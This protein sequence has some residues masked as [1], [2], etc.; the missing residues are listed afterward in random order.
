MGVLS[1]ARSGLRAARLYLG[2]G[3]RSSLRA[4]GLNRLRTGLSLRAAGLCL[5]TACLGTSN[6]S[7]LRTGLS[8][9]AARLNRLRSRSKTEA[10]LRHHAEAETAALSAASGSLLTSALCATSDLLASALCATS[11]LLASALRGSASAKA[12]TACLRSDSKTTPALL[13]APGSLLTAA[14][15]GNTPAKALT[16]CLRSDS[17]SGLRA[18]LGTSAKAE[19]LLSTLG[20][21][22]TTLSALEGSGL[23]SAKGRLC[24][25]DSGRSDSGEKDPGDCES[26]N[27]VH[28]S[29]LIMCCLRFSLLSHRAAVPSL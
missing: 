8:L 18:A 11:D 4:A 2:T 9:R 3:N 6:W 26:K 1:S 7:G 10:S 5:G 24:I 20:H 28:S 15:R 16:A 25:H 27:L 14:L 19:A 23:L 13:G 17:N 21:T 22:Q 29:L 12:L